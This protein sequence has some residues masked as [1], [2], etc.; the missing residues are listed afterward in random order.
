MNTM[1]QIFFLGIITVY[2]SVHLILMSVC[3]CVCV[4]VSIL[5]YKNEFVCMYL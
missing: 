3:V 1:H 2:V 5:M 4:R